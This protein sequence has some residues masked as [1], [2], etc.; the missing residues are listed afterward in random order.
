MR[1]RSSSIRRPTRRGSTATTTWGKCRRPSRPSRRP[2]VGPAASARLAENAGDRHGEDDLALPRRVRVEPPREGGHRSIPRPLGRQ[3]L[4]GGA[5]AEA[6]E[7][8]GE[9]GGAVRVAHAEGA[10]DAP[11]GHE[12][13]GAE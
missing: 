8:V 12:A 4:P 7:V 2:E 5:E 1:R 6:D 10:L 3:R 13:G 9:E 11:R